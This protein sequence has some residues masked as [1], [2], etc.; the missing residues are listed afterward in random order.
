MVILFKAA[1]CLWVKHA[2][3]VCCSLSCCVLP[4]QEEFLKKNPNGI[5]PVNANDVFFSVHALVLCLIYIIQAAFYEVCWWTINIPS[6][7]YSEDKSLV[8]RLYCRQRQKILGVLNCVFTIDCPQCPPNMA[9]LHSKLSC[10]F[11]C[12][13]IQGSKR[14]PGLSFHKTLCG[15]VNKQLF[16]WLTARSVCPNSTGFTLLEQ[17]ENAN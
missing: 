1:V 2:Q 15:Q 10:W 9:A 16:S 6:F 3:R 7:K 12:L 4:L 11:V 13:Y 14:A 5:N 8:T 17:R